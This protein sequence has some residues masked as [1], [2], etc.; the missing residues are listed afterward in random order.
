M[1]QGYW[2]VYEKSIYSNDAKHIASFREFEN[3]CLYIDGIL[4]NPDKVRNL[5]INGRRTESIGTYHCKYIPLSECK[6][7]LNY[8]VLP[9]GD[10]PEY[11]VRYILFD[12]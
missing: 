3:L 12:D 8:T 7:V 5:R 11:R 10:G 2:A 1:I 4:S 6:N 9:R